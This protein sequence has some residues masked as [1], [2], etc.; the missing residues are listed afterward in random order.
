MELNLMNLIKE[1]KLLFNLKIELFKVN[2][3]FGL[4]FNGIYKNGNK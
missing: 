4:L 1:L 3:L 2:C